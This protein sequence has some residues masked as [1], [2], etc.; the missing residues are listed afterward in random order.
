[1]ARAG[2]GAALLPL[3]FVRDESFRSENITLFKIKNNVHRR[4]PVIVFR[5]G[6]YLPEYAEYAIE[7]LKATDR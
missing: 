1:M 3:Q 2:I 6:Q 7:I 5:R 4:Q